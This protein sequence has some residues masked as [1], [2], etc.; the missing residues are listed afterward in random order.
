METPVRCGRVRGAVQVSGSKSIA[1]RALL[2]AARRGGLVRNVPANDDVERLCEGLRGLGFRVDEEGAARRV[3]G[4]F[5]AGDVRLDLGDN[6]TGARCLLALASLRAA[7][8][9]VDGSPQLRRRPMKPL[10]D[11]LRSLGADVAGDALPVAVAGPLQPGVVHVTTDVSSQF[12]TALVLLVDWVKG[13]RV[14]V[15]G[16][17]SLGYLA[18]TAHVQRT[19][20]DPFDV[21]PDF[22]SAAA[23]AAAAAAS[24]GDLLLRGVGLSSPQPDARAFALLRRM[25]ARVVEEEAGVRVAG[26]PLHGVQADLGACPD[27]GP[28]LGGLGALAEGETRVT[29]APQLAHK[30]SDRIARTVALVRSLGGEAEPLPDGFVVR[31]GR[32]LRGTVVDGAG[33]H[34]VVMAA[35]V[36]ALCTPGVTV[37]GSEAVA[38]SYPGF[39]ADLDSL[40]E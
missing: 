5:S 22:S 36:L 14:Q 25:G 33:D 13:L 4:S 19:F 27:L 40:T 16:R 10:C 26:G 20:Q 29:G 23:M 35:A 31:G 30:E 24:G 6:A 3:S 12:A 18:L 38:K 28:I 39:F 2:L 17:A 15:A 9:V 34:R 32:P 11:A 37:A 8:T 7:T 21:E 1:Q